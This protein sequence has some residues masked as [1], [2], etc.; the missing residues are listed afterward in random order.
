MVLGLLS[1][2]I[3]AVIAALLLV[4]AIAMLKLDRPSETAAVVLACFA[5]GLG[6]ALT[7]VGEPLGTIAIAALSADFWYLMRLL[8][9]LVVAGIVI[10]AAV[11]LFIPPH[12]RRR[13]MP[14]ARRMAGGKSSC[15]RCAS[16]PLWPGWWGFPGECARWSMLTSPVCRMRRCSG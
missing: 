4:E 2:V 3:T 6:A 12:R 16:T 13:C 8:G 7:P 1:S 10:V 14:R 5:I 15:G 11:S 9:P